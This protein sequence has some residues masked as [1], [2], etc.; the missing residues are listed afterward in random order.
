MPCEH[1][2]SPIKGSCKLLHVA[3]SA[4]DEW[5]SGKQSCR[6]FENEQLSQKIEKIHMESP[7]KGYRRRPSFGCQRGK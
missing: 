5:V 2:G 7:D 1:D 4:Y 3:R 6:T